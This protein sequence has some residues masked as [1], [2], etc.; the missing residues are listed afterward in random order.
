[1]AILIQNPLRGTPEVWKEALAKTLPKE[2]VRLFPD[3]GNP[4]EIDILMLGLPTKLAELPK[5]PNLKL[6][7]SLLAGVDAML[8]NPHLPNAPLVKAEPPVGDLMM[9]EY[10]LT[11]V[12]YH[13]RQIPLYKLNQKAH[14]WK[15]LAQKRNTDRTVGVLGYGTLGKPMGEE[16]QR[17]GFDVAAWARSPKADA[18]Y[19]VFH[20]TDGLQPFL[21][22]SEIVLNMLPLTDETRGILNAKTFAQ[23][24]KGAVLINL[25][26]GGHVVDADL[27][28]ALDS[29][30][31]SAATLDVTEPEPLPSDSPL[32]DHPRITILPH[33]AR[34]PS[35]AETMPQV[36]ENVTRLRA[37]KPLILQI[38]RRAGY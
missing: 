2:E 29:G 11:L 27:I 30:Q 35:L 38:D 4:A 34:R 36:V 5:M 6:I 26:R 12:L 13:H 23:M 25:A 32:W 19:K 37:G 18:K 7:I 8:T 20:G 17:H 21:A 9:T 24:P 31:L 15:G 33:V 22:R 14:E 1:M 16:I 10:A 3:V 28:A